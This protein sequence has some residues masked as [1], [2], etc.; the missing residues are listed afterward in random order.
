MNWVVCYIAGILSIS[1][2]IP[3]L[4]HV[5]ALGF[6]LLQSK[7]QTVDYSTAYQGDAMGPPTLAWRPA[8]EGVMDEINGIT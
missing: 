4:I 3:V 1:I 8:T 2:C 7:K 5:A 6:V